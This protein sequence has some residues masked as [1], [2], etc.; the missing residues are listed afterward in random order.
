MINELKMN[1][2]IKRVL[3]IAFTIALFGLIFLYIGLRVWIWTDASKYAEKVSLQFK[4]DKTEAL[5]MLINSEEHT[6]KEKNKAIWAL[7]VLK[8]KNA[9][10][11]L[12]MLYT[13]I[14]CRH[15][16]AI[17]Q[18]ELYKAIHKIKGDFRGSWQAKK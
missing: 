10:P 13:G 6:L 12:E 18:Y 7:G 3:I 11:K 5:L 17:C 1:S 8:E 9:L 2:K 14:E 15:D 4:T 16:S